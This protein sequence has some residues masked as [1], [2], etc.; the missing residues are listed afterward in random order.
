MRRSRQKQPAARRASG[1]VALRGP[2]DE[3]RPS[4]NG[5]GLQG[6]HRPEPLTWP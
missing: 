3:R 6:R 1:I 4:R 2:S 5:T